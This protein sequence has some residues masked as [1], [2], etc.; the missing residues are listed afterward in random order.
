[1]SSSSYTDHQLKKI[2][3]QNIGI[4]HTIEFL[5]FLRENLHNALLSEIERNSS[6]IEVP[7]K[8]IEINYDKLT[9]PYIKKIKDTKLDKKIH[10]FYNLN[11]EVNILIT[12]EI[13]H[14]ISEIYH[15]INHIIILLILLHPDRRFKDSLKGLEKNKKH[16][17]G[18]CW[19]IIQDNM[20]WIEEFKEMRGKISHKS[21]FIFYLKCRIREENS[22]IHLTL[23]DNYENKEYDIC[24]IFEFL[25]KLINL[26]KGIEEEKMKLLK[27]E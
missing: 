12:K 21:P 25:D 23:E 26:F 1:M 19:A 10:G 15:S 24:S 17:K 27:K 5:I 14:F 20:Q 13:S 7:E 3:Q 4:S 6:M 18:N 9:E 11:F 2:E 22:T 8:V 16:L